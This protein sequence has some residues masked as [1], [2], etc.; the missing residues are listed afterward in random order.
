MLVLEIIS[1]IFHKQVWK[2]ILDGNNHK[3][4]IRSKPGAA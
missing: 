1:D 2:N 3:I 4:K